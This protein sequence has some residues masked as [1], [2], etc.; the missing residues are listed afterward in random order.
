MPR[1]QPFLVSHEINQ[2]AYALGGGRVLLQQRRRSDRPGHKVATA[3]RAHPEEHG[4]D[5]RRTECALKASN[6]GLSRVRWK[7]EVKVLAVRLER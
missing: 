5:T 4:V 2:F 7:V 6:A 3:V 1:R